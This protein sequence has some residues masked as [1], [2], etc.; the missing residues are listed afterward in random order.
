LAV[1]WADPR[2]VRKVDRLVARKVGRSA[3]YWGC[4]LVVLWAGST[5][6]G[7]GAPLAARKAFWMVALKAEQ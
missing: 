5:V 2:V 4:R 7:M 6:A 3:G 1:D